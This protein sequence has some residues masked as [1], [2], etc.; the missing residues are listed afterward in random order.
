VNVSTLILLFA[1]QSPADH[2]NSFLPV[3]GGA[4]VG[5]LVSLGTTLIV[6]RFR[7]KAQA[8][9]AAAAEAVNV[10]LA[11]R[12]VQLELRQIEAVLR[13]TV[14]RES[15]RWPVEP[16]YSFPVAAWQMYAARLAARLPR[17][18]WE[19]IA[20]PYSLFEHINLSSESLT[21]EGARE[22]LAGAQEALKVIGS[23]TG[24][25]EPVG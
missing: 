14:D 25:R 1:N 7:T 13:L 10:K 8:R 20:T 19:V 5:G 12:L 6:E 24:D 17:K 16:G 2:G 18:G 9:A 23:W 21:E 22:L 15:F 11:A 4:V 3:L